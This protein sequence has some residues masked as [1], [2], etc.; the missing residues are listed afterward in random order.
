[1]RAAVTIALLVATSACAPPAAPRGVAAG[2]LHDATARHSFADV[3]HWRSVFDD[4]A[5]DAWQKPAALMRA[6]D[7]RPGTCVADVGAGTGYFSRYL[8]AAV[9]PGG[10]VLAVEPEP[11][12]VVHLRERAEREG[13][14]N[15]VP[16]LASLDNPRLPVGGVDLLLLVDTMHHLDDRIAYFR[17]AR[18]F[19]RPGGRIA[20]VDWRE[21]ELP[22]G[23]PPA[24]RLAREQVIDELRAAGYALVAEPKDLLPYQ[25]VLIFRPAR[26]GA[27]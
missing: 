27:G 18:R 5:R 10:T 24:H 6:L 23:P 2:G 17:R 7:L 3:E 11:N 19:L 13:T 12:L 16:V 15:V 4:P 1:V 26:V 20:V 25:Y 21:G 9:G 14:D 22:V 8:S